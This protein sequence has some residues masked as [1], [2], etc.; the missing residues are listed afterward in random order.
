MRGGPA[1]ERLGAAAHDSTKSRLLRPFMMSALLIA[2]LT[3]SQTAPES[4]LDG[5]PTTLTVVPAWPAGRFVA[6]DAALAFTL[7]RPLEPRA[8][9]LA[10][11]VGTTDFGGF[12][13][14][15]GTRVT[16]HLRG[17]RLS[18][19]SHEVVVYRVTESGWTELARAAVNLLTRGGFE[20][21]RVT[22]SVTLNNAGQLAERTSALETPSP[23]PTFQHF[24]GS[25]GLQGALHRSGVT[26]E[27]QWNV[28]GVSEREQA[29]RFGQ[30]QDQ[31]PLVDLADFTV[32]LKRGSV[33]VS[34]GNLAIGQQRH[35]LQQFTSRGVTAGFTRGPATLTVAAANGSSI[36]GWDNLLGVADR[37]HLVRTAMLG[38]DLLPARPGSLRLET[39][40][41]G[42]TSRPLPGVTRGAIIDAERGDG[43]GVAL[44]AQT[45]GQR[46]RLRAEWAR[47][48]MRPAG[49]DE[50]TGDTTVVP[51]GVARGDAR[52]AELSADLLRQ[53][54]LT[55]WLS[56][57]LSI[58]L[59]HE[60]VDPGYRSVATTP[61]ADRE[62]TAGEVALTL[63]ALALRGTHGRTGDNLDGVASVLR[64]VNR[65]SLATAT[66]PLSQLA[67]RRARLAPWLPALSA[68]WS[69][70]H[71]LADGIPTNGDFRP[72]DLPD[73]LSVAGDVAAQ[74]SLSRWRVGYRF[75]HSSQDNRQPGRE[76]ADFTTGVHALTLGVAPSTALD[77]AVDATQ[78]RQENAE[79]SQAQRLRRVG[80]TATW[81]LTRLAQL[82]GGYTA[83]VSRDQPS[84]MRGTQGDLRAELSHGFDV[85][86][87][88]GG[89]GARG[90]VFVRYQRLSA[91]TQQLLEAA[92]PALPPGKRLRW[93]VATG[94][95]YRVL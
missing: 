67:A 68:T 59:R 64:T 10:F 62:E 51:L 27:T 1:T 43:Q 44:S 86:G 26:V 85:R 45:A 74:W 17:T 18:S 57:D 23:D 70:T 90:R 87:R 91:E 37:G 80:T 79:L 21:V 63:G 81:Q 82:S 88:V 75:N 31:A 6:G 50:L 46:L 71:A 41:L 30:E 56:A 53:R 84:T 15:A 93:S 40:L 2:S 65:Q 83:T 13:T 28:S 32:S 33:A 5:V 66:L 73:Q 89:G 58:A 77:V 22:P 11:V 16:L 92:T 8:E 7:S 34:L 12:A 95:S 4:S 20:S 54:R 25:A 55:S 69:R 72:V 42:G 3:L 9:G 38:L 36:V 29:L 49:D 48:R 24:T 35:L 52:W 19:G 76:R 78:E 39:T 61:Q 47:S 60:R 94:L 14:D